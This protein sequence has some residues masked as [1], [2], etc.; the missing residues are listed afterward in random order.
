MYP[1]LLPNTSTFRP[2]ENADHGLRNLDAVVRGDAG[3]ERLAREELSTYLQLLRSGHIARDWRADIDSALLLLYA[4]LA[5][6]LLLPF[7]SANCKCVLE[8]VVPPLLQCGCF[9]V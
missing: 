3:V 6:P 8:H 9:H 2:L 7:V 1:G 4:Q 5:S